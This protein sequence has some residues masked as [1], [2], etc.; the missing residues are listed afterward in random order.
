MAEQPQPLLHWAWVAFGTRHLFI[1]Y[2]HKPLACHATKYFWC[3]FMDRLS[4][5]KF[6]IDTWRRQSW[7]I[8]GGVGVFAVGWGASGGTDRVHRQAGSVCTRQQGEADQGSEDTGWGTQPCAGDE[9]GGRRRGKDT[10]TVSYSHRLIVASMLHVVPG[11]GLNASL[12][13]CIVLGGCTAITCT[14][15]CCTHSSCLL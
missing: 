6:L 12:Q 13:L 7:V 4:L 9:R 14:C 8:C 10:P 3:L 1:Q 5:Y 11:A 2:I 15:S